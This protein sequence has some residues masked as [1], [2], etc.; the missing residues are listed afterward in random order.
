MSTYCQLQK[1]HPVS[2]LLNC[3]FKSMGFLLW[4][5]APCYCY[6]NKGIPTPHPTMKSMYVTPRNNDFS[7]TFLLC[8]LVIPA[9]VKNAGGVVYTQT[10][11]RCV[12][13]T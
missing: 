9:R 2:D 8:N 11:S 5:V 7:I 6:A 1:T 13:L 3:T 4:D 12:Q 10:M